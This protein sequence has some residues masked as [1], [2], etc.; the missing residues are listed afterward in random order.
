MSPRQSEKLPQ[1][2]SSRSAPQNLPSYLPGMLLSHQDGP[3]C[4][5]MHHTQ[6]HTHALVQAALSIACMSSLAQQLP[7][8]VPD[9]LTASSCGGPCEFYEEAHICACC[10]GKSASARGRQRH[11][12]VL[13]VLLLPALTGLAVMCVRLRS[14]EKEHSL[15]LPPSATVYA[16][17]GPEEGELYPLMSL[18]DIQTSTCAQDAI[19]WCNSIGKNTLKAGST[20]EG[21][22]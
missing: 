4:S 19:L 6:H 12:L 1:H 17:R 10:A 13:L 8:A 2:S 21:V 3:C 9:G 15:I 22:S 7:F 5:H 20:F 18:P 16:W 14:S 11:Q